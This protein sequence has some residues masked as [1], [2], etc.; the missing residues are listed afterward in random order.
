MYVNLGH[1]LI[2]QGVART[3]ERTYQGYFRYWNLFR[4][5]VGLSFFTLTGA[6]GESHAR[7]LLTYIAYASIINGL[8]AGTIAGHLAAVKFF[9]RQERELELFSRHPGI[10]D[11][12]KGVPRFHAEVGTQWR[13]AV[14]RQLVVSD[15]LLRCRESGGD[16]SPYF[17]FSVG[18]V[19]MHY[20]LVNKDTEAK[21]QR[22]GFQNWNLEFV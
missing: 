9:H 20:G 19:T 12:L 1:E 18:R 7:S 10:A 11:A 13:L 22:E 15:F 4:V 21:L 14:C 5:S 17:H 6:R 8:M 2:R 3:S 16:A